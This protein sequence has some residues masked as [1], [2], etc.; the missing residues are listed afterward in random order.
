[1]TAALLAL[2]LAAAPARIEPS[3]LMLAAEPAAIELIVPGAEGLEAKVM[4]GAGSLSGVVA[5]GG[6]KFKATFQFPAQRYP[7]LALVLISARQKGGVRQ[8]HWVALPLVANA[9]LKIE[10]KPSATV[11]VSIGELKFGPATADARG[12]LS[13]PAK[14]PPGFA[15]AQ[16]VAVDRA[17]N[18]TTS[19]LDLSPQPFSRAAAALVGQRVTPDALSE[20]EV[21][22]AEGDGRPLADAATLKVSA[23]RGTVGAPQQRAAGVFSVSYRAPREVGDGKDTVSVTAGDAPEQTLEIPLVGGAGAQVAIELGAPAFIA[24]SGARIPLKAVV[25][26]AHGNAA[27]GLQA[28]LSVD[29]GAVEETPNGPQLMVPDAFGGRREVK[30][31]ATAAGLSGEAALPLKAGAAVKAQLE[32]PANVSA[33]AQAHGRLIATD[34]YGNTVEP[35]AVEVTTKSGRAATVQRGSDGALEVSWEAARDQ[36]PGDVEL[37]A[38]SGGASLSRRTIEVL[39][40]ERPWAISVGAFATGAW[41]FAQA[42]S[43]SPRLA[44][45]LRLGRSGFELGVEGAFAWYP[46]LDKTAHTTDGGSNS[47]L[48]ATAWSVAFAARYTLRLA[49]HW[50]L[51]AAGALGGQFTSATINVPGFEQ[52]QTG[53]WSPLIRGAIGA[54]FHLAVGR[55]VLQVEYA[56]AQPPPNAP[57]RGNLAGL[58]VALGYVAAF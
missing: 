46:L 56:W 37:E 1:V 32:L 28:A 58:G 10:T 3:A 11:T 30:V 31:R 19:A 21:F 57:V 44:A 13:I 8:R 49:A 2:A 50:S 36:A 47:S 9:N 40:F 55:I 41:N 22:A 52:L 25:T 33:G 16:V 39:P 15:T 18:S 29:F 38:R 42:R 5:A 27:S 48:E 34:A 23:A 12:K 53:F 43:F 6:G 4:N 20:L 17:S 51:H 26:D 24:G 7:Q 54:G 14:V 35:D 45:G